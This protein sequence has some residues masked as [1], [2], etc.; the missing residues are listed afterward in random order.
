MT[1]PE[2]IP[3]DQVVAQLWEY[4]DGELSG[5]RAER[6]RAHLDVCAR[7]FPEYDFHRAFVAFLGAHAECP[8]PPALRQ[9]VFERLL[10]EDASPSDPAD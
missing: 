4:I 6:V 9:K 10:R 8:I 7:C 3:C 1:T 2:M 5:E